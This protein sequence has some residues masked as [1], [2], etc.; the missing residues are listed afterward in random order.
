MKAFVF[1]EELDLL[2]ELVAGATQ[3]AG[4]GAEV[5]AIA[6]SDVA[7]EVKGATKVLSVELPADA[8]VDAVAPSIALAVEEAQPVFVLIGATRIGRSIAARVAAKLG[9]SAIVDAKAVE[10]VD[11][12]PQVL[13]MLFGGAALRNDVATGPV[14]VITLPAAMYEPLGAASGSVEAI[15]WVEPAA[16]VVKKGTRKKEASSKDV[17]TEKVVVCGGAGLKSRDDLAMIEDLANKLDGVTGCT[18]PLTE[19][20]DA[21]FSGEPYIGCSGVY[22]RPD[23][24]IGVGVSGQT[25][26]TVGFEDAKVTV[27]INS[28]KNASIFRYSDYGI[29]GDFR[30][31]VPALASLIG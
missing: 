23:L 11:G 10:M 30:A 24:Y 4:E 22:V 15:N 6:L 27:A 31:V 29:V 14:S 8:P 19:G 17:T 20:A 1:S 16:K 3:L 9:T 5:T 26:H 28:D 25:Q 13:H 2:N 7:F 12:A 21:L 18:R